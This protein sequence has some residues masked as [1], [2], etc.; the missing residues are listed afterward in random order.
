[1]IVIQKMRYA[2]TAMLFA[3][4]VTA[5]ASCAGRTSRS[6][7]VSMVSMTFQPADLTVDRGDTIVWKNDDFLPHTATARDS[8]WDSKSVDAGASWRYVADKSGRYSYYCMFHPNMQ[9]TIEV[10]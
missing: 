6:Y 7:M 8:S 5:S 10:R 9:G 2:A 4:A 3:V 1:M